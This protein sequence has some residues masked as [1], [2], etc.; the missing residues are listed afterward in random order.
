[1]LRFIRNLLK[2]KKGVAALEY[3]ILA[4]LIVL[5]VVAT[6][7]TANVKSGIAGVFSGV[8][9]ALSNAASGNSTTTTTTGG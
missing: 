7:N 8:T 5:G 2:D 6:I 1:M 3:A 4:G 9:S